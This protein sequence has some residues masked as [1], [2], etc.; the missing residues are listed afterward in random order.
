MQACPKPLVPNQNA[1]NR[2]DSL[3]P[4][5]QERIFTAQ[6]RRFQIIPELQ[7]DGVKK[8]WSLRVYLF[9]APSFVTQSCQSFLSFSNAGRASEV[10]MGSHMLLPCCKYATF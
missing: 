3:M 6:L 1:R 9:P 7:N 5:S 2:I 8:P 4:Q 10:A